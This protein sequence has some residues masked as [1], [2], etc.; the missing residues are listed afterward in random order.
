MLSKDIVANMDPTVK[1]VHDGDLD[2]YAIHEIRQMQAV[3]DQAMEQL[4]KVTEENQQLKNQIQSLFTELANKREERS[5]SW[6][7]AVLDNQVDNRRLDIEEAKM[8]AEVGIDQGKLSLETQKV[9]MEAQD[10]LD[11]TI[12]KN[13][14]MINEITGGI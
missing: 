6:N 2:E 9:A 11:D 4:E 13:D 1:L 5:L 7:K 3:A 8:G 14:Q 12:E 10:R